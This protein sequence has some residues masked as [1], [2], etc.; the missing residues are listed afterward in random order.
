MR[1]VIFTPPLAATLIQASVA[2]RS[3]WFGNLTALSA[4]KGSRKSLWF[5]FCARNGRRGGVTPMLGLAACRAAIVQ[6]ATVAYRY[7]DEGEIHPPAPKLW[8]TGNGCRQFAQQMV[9]GDQLS[10]DHA[11]ET[12]LIA[13]FALY[14]LPHRISH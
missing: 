9:G 2:I 10:V 13:V 3:L 8:R 1:E 5:C 11:K 4:P 14:I 6:A 12:A 7:G